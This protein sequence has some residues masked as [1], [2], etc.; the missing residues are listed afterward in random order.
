MWLNLLKRDIFQSPHRRQL[1]SVLDKLL[2]WD[3]GLLCVDVGGE[4]HKGRFS[5]YSKALDA[6]VCIN[7]DIANKPDVLGDA[8]QLPIRSASVD[9]VLCFETLEHVRDVDVVLDEIYRVCKPGGMIFCSVPFLYHQHG[10]PCDYRRY[11]AKGLESLLS[12]RAFTVQNVIKLGSFMDVILTLVRSYLLR[13][14]KR[15]FVFA[16]LYLPFYSV[17]KVF[18]L[19]LD[20]HDSSYYTGVFI[21]GVKN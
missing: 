17:C 19:F 8:E 5:D 16:I 4:R 7:L 6:S 9:V 14:S 15:F 21:T 3:A 12:K 1:E 18:S 2:E 20:H 10:D 13:R 11:T